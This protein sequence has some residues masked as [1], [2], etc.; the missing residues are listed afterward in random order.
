MDA[1]MHGWMDA[2]VDGWMDA[3]M[4]GRTDGWMHGC[5]DEWRDVWMR[6]CMDRWMYGWIHGWIVK[7]SK[8]P[9]TSSI[10][11]K[12]KEGYEHRTLYLFASTHPSMH[13]CTHAILRLKSGMIFSHAQD[14]PLK[15]QSSTLIALQT[16]METF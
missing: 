4:D 7:E 8:V 15:L 6:E 3:L 5:V 1:W 14:I 16:L 2:C 13:P 12:V 9:D 11:N 10:S